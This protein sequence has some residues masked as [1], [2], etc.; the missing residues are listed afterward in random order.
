MRPPGALRA[1]LALLAV[2]ALCRAQELR[3]SAE[4]LLKILQAADTHFGED[5]KADAQTAQV[6]L[7]LALL[8]RSSHSL[9]RL[10]PAQKRLP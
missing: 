3:F 9:R 8:C 2:G 7:N 6:S 1:L 4:G 5:E 10:Q